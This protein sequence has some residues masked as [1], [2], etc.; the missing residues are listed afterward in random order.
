MRLPLKCENAGLWR[1]AASFMMAGVH[2][3]GAPTSSTMLAMA[4]AITVSSGPRPGWSAG[5][6]TP[7][8]GVGC[9]HHRV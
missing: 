5:V 8:F 4:R 9:C 7:P 1:A 2:W 3:S 6:W